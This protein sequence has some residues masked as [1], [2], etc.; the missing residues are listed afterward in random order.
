MMTIRANLPFKVCPT[1]GK[2]WSTREVF[3]DDAFVP[4]IG[5]QAHFADPLRGLFIFGHKLAICGTTLAI[6]VEQFDFLYTGIKHTELLALSEA[7]PGYCVEKH[8]FQKCGNACS[9]AFVREILNAIKTHKDAL[10]LNE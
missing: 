7:C 6:K 2:T 10:A 8:R 9:M 3:L 5:Y 1:C 4:I